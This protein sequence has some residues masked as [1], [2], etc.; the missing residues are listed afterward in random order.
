VEREVGNPTRVWLLG[1]EEEH[2]LLSVGK[3]LTTGKTH[4]PNRVITK[5][6]YLRHAQQETEG[7]QIQLQRQDSQIVT[8][9][10]YSWTAPVHTLTKNKKRT[11]KKRTQ[12]CTGVE[13]EQN[14]SK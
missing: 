10:N 11:R 7:M 9:S 8:P 13:Q 5:P 4:K 14:H 12:K 3:L 6:R 2:N 1:G